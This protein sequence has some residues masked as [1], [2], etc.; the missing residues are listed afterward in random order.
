MLRQPPILILE[1]YQARRQTTNWPS[2]LQVNHKVSLKFSFDPQNP[3]EFYFWIE[4]PHKRH[5]WAIAD[6]EIVLAYPPTIFLQ[7]VQV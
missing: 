7:C 5:Q 4:K 2:K 1:N 3:I 6:A